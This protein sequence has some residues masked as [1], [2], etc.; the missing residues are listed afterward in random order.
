MDGEEMESFLNFIVHVTFTAWLYS[1]AYVN[2]FN[3][4]IW[5][6]SVSSPMQVK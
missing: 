2:S 3:E 4:R 5:K 1:V 6:S